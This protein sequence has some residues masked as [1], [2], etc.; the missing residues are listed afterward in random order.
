MRGTWSKPFS[1]GR[2]RDGWETTRTS[3]PTGGTALRLPSTTLRVAGSGPKCQEEDS[4][5]MLTSLSAAVLMEHTVVVMVPPI[6][7]PA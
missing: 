5:S 7:A 6:T 3:R 1:A 4:V 2:S